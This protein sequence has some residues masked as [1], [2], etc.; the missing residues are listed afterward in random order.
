ML[1]FAKNLTIFHRVKAIFHGREKL[2]IFQFL[3]KPEKTALHLYFF[4]KNLLKFRKNSEI[5]AKSEKKAY[6]KKIHP[7]MTILQKSS[8]NQLFFLKIA[9]QVLKIRHFLKMS[10]F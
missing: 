3:S 9:L 8:K 10:N 1:N 2:L 4:P 7:K 5:L 6:N